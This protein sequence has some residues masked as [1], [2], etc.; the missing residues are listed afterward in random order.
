MSPR[1]AKI[2]FEIEHMDPLG[3]GVSRA[4]KTVTFIAGTLPGETGE[5][6]VFKKSKGVQ[7]ARLESLEKSAANR[8][9]PSCP[10]FQQ[11]P[12]CQYLH[13]DYSSELQYKK[14]ALARHLSPLGIAED[15]IELVSAPRRLAY[16][17]RVQLHYRH[18]YIGM[19]DPVSNQVVEIPD[20]QILRQE[21]QPAFD[22]L[23][24]DKSWTKEH[25]GH[26]HCE[27]YVRDGDVSE[28]WNS[29]Y[30]HGGFSQVYEEMNG[31]LQARVQTQLGGLSASSV[32]DLF[33]GRGNLSNEFSSAGGDRVLVDSH[34]GGDTQPPEYFIKL[35]L[36]GEDALKLFLRRTRKKTFDTLLVDPPR[37]G[38]PDLNNWVKKIKPK[39][40]L[41]VS[42]NPAS[43]ARDLRSLSSKF[44]IGEVQLLDLFPATYHFETLVLLHFR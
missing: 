36:Y 29:D 23:Y 43:L 7:F 32:L 30:S 20:C 42:C 10:H 13:T 28:Q 21:L 18:K 19:L 33:S 41:Y 11:C 14:S 35:D 44:R 39:H 38:F 4:G 16:R 34:W 9:E 25:T 12:G 6:V 5:A 31:Q 1:V 37:R 15:S 24:R 8:C 17:N 2:E 3:Q 22:A 40:L 27:L 26:G